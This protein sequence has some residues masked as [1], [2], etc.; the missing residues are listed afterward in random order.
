MSI[1]EVCNREVVVTAPDT[2]IAVAARLMREH[3]VGDLV[4]VEDPAG[5]PVPV[6]IVTDRDLVVEV[7]APEVAPE[8][9]TVR[10]V[11]SVSC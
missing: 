1:G 11:M 5:A 3:H 8:S 2:A 6:G 9:V 7:L 10:D 4:V